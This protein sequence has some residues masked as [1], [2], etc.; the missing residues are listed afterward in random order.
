[1]RVISLTRSS[2]S[3]T[4][5]NLLYSPRNTLKL[6]KKSH[7]GSVFCIFLFYRRR[8]CG[9]DGFLETVGHFI[10]TLLTESAGTN[11]GA[12]GFTCKLNHR[13][14]RKLKAFFSQPL[15]NLRYLNITFSCNFLNTA[16]AVILNVGLYFLELLFKSVP[17]LRANKRSHSIVKQSAA[18]STITYV[19]VNPPGV[20]GLL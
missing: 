3:I 18:F 6:I 16:S 5:L 10:L 7:T 11:G 20:N 9:S 17:A 19:H 2:L 1:M 15:L 14:F 13:I 12:A 4:H 8:S